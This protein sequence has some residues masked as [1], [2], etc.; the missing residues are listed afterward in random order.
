MRVWRRRS[1]ATHPIAKAPEPA[2]QEGLDIDRKL[3]AQEPGNAQAS[4]P[5][6]HPNVRFGGAPT[7]G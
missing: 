1:M 3:A 4:E 7:V 2:N 6:R 5:A